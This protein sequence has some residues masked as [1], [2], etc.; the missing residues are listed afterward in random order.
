MRRL[1]LVSILLLAVPS[2]AGARG[3]EDVVAEVRRATARYVDVANARAAGY[4][5]ASGMERHHG[6]HFVQ[7]VAQARALATGALDLA[8]PPVLL[9]VERGGAWQLVGVEY[10]LP[11]PPQDDPLRV[12]LPR[13]FVTRCLNGS[14]VDHKYDCT[15]RAYP[16]SSVPKAKTTAESVPLLRHRLRPLRQR[17]ETCRW[18]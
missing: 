12:K 6:Y 10:A 13:D 3:A 5:Q 14:L 1:A 11:S 2:V 7:P 17:Q 4:L 8:T 15:C 16:D 18:P 9:Y